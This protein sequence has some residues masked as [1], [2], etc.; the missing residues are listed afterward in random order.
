MGS[1]H[2]PWTASTG[3]GQQALPGHG[4]GPGVERSRRGVKHR[5]GFSWCLRHFWFETRSPGNP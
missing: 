1:E 4:V 5:K 3:H 2:W